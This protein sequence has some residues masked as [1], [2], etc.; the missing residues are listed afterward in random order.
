M[1]TAAIVGTLALVAVTAAGELKAEPVK[2]RPTA[3][4]CHLT[5]LLGP[6]E[7]ARPR[8]GK[9]A[10]GF[11]KADQLVVDDAAQSISV[12]VSVVILSRPWCAR[13]SGIPER[14][15]VTE[16]GG[17]EP[18]LSIELKSRKV[19]LSDA[20]GAKFTAHEA[21][22]TTTV[23]AMKALLDKEGDFQLVYKDHVFKEHWQKDYAAKLV[24]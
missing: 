5:I 3:E 24:Q 4:A 7:F 20:T 17:R 12:L 15:I 1:D 23:G 9:Q 16:K 2:I 13:N 21:S 6:A 11:E 22:G 8:A 19:E 18:L 14:I 10:E